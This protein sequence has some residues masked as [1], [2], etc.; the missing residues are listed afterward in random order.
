MQ[1]QVDERAELG[2]GGASLPH[3]FALGGMRF[4]SVAAA[5]DVGGGVV[6]GLGLNGA[7]GAFEGSGT[8]AATGGAL[9]EDLPDATAAFTARWNSSGD[10]TFGCAGI[11]SGGTT[12]GVGGADGADRAG[13]T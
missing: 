2:R 12:R 10:T 8:A 1:A 3:G 6:G 11:R 13:T 9:T 5:A 7:L 4:E